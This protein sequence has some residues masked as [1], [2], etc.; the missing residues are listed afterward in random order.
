MTTNRSLNKVNV[1]RMCGGS[2]ANGFAILLGLL[3]C[4]GWAAPQAAAQTAGEGSI[5]GT[6]KDATGAL[7]A[8]ATV[9]A[10]NNA[11]NVATTRISSSAGFYSISPLPDR[12]SV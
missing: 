11:T 5:V 3:F 1:R 2:W 8:S 6:V 10:T 4:L 12:K 9:T 7:I